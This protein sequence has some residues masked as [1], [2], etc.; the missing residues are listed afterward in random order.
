MK[1]IG[2]ELG[3]L[4]EIMVLENHEFERSTETLA[5][6]FSLRCNGKKFW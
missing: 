3:V 4:S 1:G 5:R 6:C 2:G